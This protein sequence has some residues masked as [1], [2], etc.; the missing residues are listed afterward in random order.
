MS[1]E[2]RWDSLESHQIPGWF[3]DATF[4]VYF[5]W[6][7]YAV[8]AYD[9]EWYPRNMYREGTDAYEHHVETYGP[10]KEVGYREFIPDFHGDEFDPERWVDLCDEAGAEY[11]GVT[12]I[13]HDGFALWDSDITE[14]NA[15]N[16]GPERDVVGEFAVAVRDRD[17]KF[18]A[19]FHHAWNWWYYPRAE[20][21]DT[22]DPAY[23]GLYGP[24]HEEGEDPPE[25]YYADWRDKTLEAMEAYRPDLVWFDFGWGIGP[26]AAHDDY[27]R[28]VVAG[29]YNMAEEWGKEVGI[30]HKRNLPV[31]IGILDYER[32]RREERSNQP[33]LTD[34]S[35]DRRSWGYISDPDYKSVRTLVTGLVDRL[36]KYG[37]TL[38]NVGPRPDGTI[39]KP[40]ADRLRGI[41]AWLDTNGEAVR[42]TRP[43]WVFGEGPTDVTSSE[44]EE[45]SAVTFTDED[46]RF[47]RGK[48]G[49]PAYAVLLEWP[50]DGEVELETSLHRRLTGRHRADE[51][52]NPDRVKLLGADGDPE[53]RV[54]EDAGTLR[55]TLPRRNG[56]EHAYVLRLDPST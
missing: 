51:P 54:N 33:W 11:V 23:A 14:W 26:F 16:M 42:G 2:T 4:G 53:W 47:L 40:A 24:P 8:P 12:A 18:V 37:N 41:G 50:A 6:G 28:E 9:N 35:A 43:W 44:F 34:T 7:P 10:P 32:S 45:A 29:Y 49:D 55:I 56:L 48:P 31:G 3:R 13:H 27:R 20:E 38:L 19:A 25:S 21:Y 39:P 17:M 52:V 30:A 22:T 1:Y 15:A 5:H 36:S 46:V